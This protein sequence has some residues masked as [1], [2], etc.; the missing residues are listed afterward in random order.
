MKHRSAALVALSGTFHAP[1]FAQNA[2]DSM[3]AHLIAARDAAGFD[4][5]GTLARLCVAPPFV[6]RH[7]GLRPRPSTRA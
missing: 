1:S 5:T 6:T 3:D 4:F 7:P 2:P